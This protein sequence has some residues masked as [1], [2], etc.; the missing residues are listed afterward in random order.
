MKS[1]IELPKD[2]IICDIE[3]TGTDIET[4]EITEISAL[5]Y[6]DEKLVDSF[7]YLI[8]INQQLDPFIIELTGITDELLKENGK[9]LKDVLMKFLDFVND[10]YL[11]FHNF[12]FDVRFLKYNIKKLLNIDYDPKCICTLR[13]SRKRFKRFSNCSLTD[14][15]KEYKINTIGNHRAIKDC[16]ITNEIYQNLKKDLLD[17]YKTIDL[18]KE[19]FKYN[20]KKITREDIEIDYE[21]INQDNPFFEKHS[22][23]TGTMEKMNRNTAKEKLFK[24]GGYIDESIT[25]ETNYLIQANKILNTKDGKSNKQKDVEKK[26]LKG[27]DID[28]I[29]ENTFYAI[30]DEFEQK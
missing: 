18:L 22:C 16:K 27:Q 26:K 8:K 28:L 13:L 15:A 19:S 30:L 9:D 6:R 17:E 11:I 12:S 20:Y 1:L 25:K 3:T 7:N 23:I 5:K 10:D 4:D 29:T 24:L 14:I 21:N 2:Y